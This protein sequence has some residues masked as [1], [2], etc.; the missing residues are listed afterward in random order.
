MDEMNELEFLKNLRG[1]AT[2]SEEDLVDVICIIASPSYDDCPKDVIFK[3]AKSAVTKLI[4]VIDE[5][6]RRQKEVNNGF[7]GE[8]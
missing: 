4:K 1:I 5:V 8:V 2:P 6:D 3:V 7:A